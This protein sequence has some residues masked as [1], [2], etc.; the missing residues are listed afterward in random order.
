MDWADEIF[1]VQR[2]VADETV[3]AMEAT[4][5]VLPPAVADDEEV[6]EEVD[7][8]PE[9]GSEIAND[10]DDGGGALSDQQQK[11]LDII[12]EGGRSVFFTGAAGTGKSHLLRAIVERL[13]ERG[14]T[15]AVT[16][17]TGAAACNVGGTTLHSFAGICRCEGSSEDMASAA[18]RNRWAKKRWCA[19]KVLYVPIALPN[20]S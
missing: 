8:V 13:R 10:S 11:V 20:R 5:R 1:A 15:V 7:I 9:E 14:S 6:G 4:S 3:I 16:G 17:A 2:P 19:T 12:V 18:V